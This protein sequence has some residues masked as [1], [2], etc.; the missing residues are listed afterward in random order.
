MGPDKGLPGVVV[1]RTGEVYIDGHLIRGVIDLRSEV[2]HREGITLSMD[3]RPGSIVMGDPPDDL[4][5]EMHKQVSDPDATVD[6]QHAI[7]SA[8]RRR[9]TP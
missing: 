7:E 2:D 9:K 4:V 6:I 1:T 8:L 5:E 3:I